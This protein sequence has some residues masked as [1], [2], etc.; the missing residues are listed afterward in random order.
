MKSL[1]KSILFLI[2][3]CVAANLTFAAGK[4]TKKAAAK[5]QQFETE[6]NKA[7]AGTK[8]GAKKRRRR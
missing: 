5:A 8:Y 1:K 3:L 4:K 7:F 2:T 6:M